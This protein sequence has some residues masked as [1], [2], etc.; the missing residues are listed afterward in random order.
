M[1]DSFT[2]EID[3]V[4]AGIDQNITTTVQNNAQDIEEIT[5]PIKRQM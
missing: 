4:K 1:T 3:E 5:G 2:K